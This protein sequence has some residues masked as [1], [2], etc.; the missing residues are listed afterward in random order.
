M[1]IKSYMEVL[2]AKFPLIQAHIVGDPSI[3]ENIVVDSGP[4]LPSK[5]ILDAAALDVARTE[6]WAKIQGERDKR[7]ISGV[8]V[9]SNWF[10]SDDPSRIQQIALVMMGAN[11]PPNIMWKTM[12]GTF[13]LMTPTLANQIF[14]GIVAR[15]QAIFA[16]AE[17]H[18]QAMI[19]TTD[20]PYT[21]DWTTGWP[22][23]Y[24]EWAAQQVP[25]APPPA[26]APE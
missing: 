23:S 12:M 7:R 5:D 1:I 8:Q 4:E 6:M 13:V 26:P 19:T 9:G 25:P 22:Q 21:Y 3:Y 14:Q 16:K 24:V 20:D 10:H 18:R 15:D 17:Q 2:A 11:M